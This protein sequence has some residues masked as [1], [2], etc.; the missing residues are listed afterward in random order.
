MDR[1]DEKYLM[2]LLCTQSQENNWTRLFEELA[3]T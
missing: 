1:I 3:V 2:R